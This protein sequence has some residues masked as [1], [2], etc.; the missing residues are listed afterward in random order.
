MIVVIDYNVGNVKSVR[1]ALDY[2]GIEDELSAD[3]DRIAVAD[4][5]ILPG[6]AAFGYAI[7]ALGSTAEVVHHAVLNGKPLLGICVGYQLLFDHS[8]E[9]G[10]HD[11]LGLIGGQVVPIPKDQTVPH[12]GW[13]S[14]HLP[15]GMDLFDGLRS[16]EHFY[17]AHSFHARIE[18]PQARIAL[19]D[20]G[21][22]MSAAVQKGNIYG[23]QFHPEK[24]GPVG[25]RVL[26]NFEA[27]CR[28]AAKC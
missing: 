12:M 4:G 15:E 2:L 27:I 23:V 6:V 26:W 14:V 11:G 19:T 24:S 22:P 8:C 7:Q 1:N 20:Y 21:R 3:P 5:I 9:L 16:E 25:M 10:E 13:N 18:D 17:F 28:R